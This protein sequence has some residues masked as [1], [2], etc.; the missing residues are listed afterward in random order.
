MTLPLCCYNRTSPTL[1]ILL[2]NAIGGSGDEL[3][4]TEPMS[5]YY[6]NLLLNMSVAWLL[7]PLFP[8]C[9]LIQFSVRFSKTQFVA[10]TM[11]TS[12]FLWLFILFSR[13]HK[14]CTGNHYSSSH[15][16]CYLTS[17]LSIG[18]EIYVPNLPAFGLHGSLF[19][20]IFDE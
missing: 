19:F 10:A 6:R 15:N 4:G 7:I 14:V 17:I 1:N 2:Y 20:A 16:F 5:Y 13:P 18:G 12:A 9:L 8:L 3:Y 11:G